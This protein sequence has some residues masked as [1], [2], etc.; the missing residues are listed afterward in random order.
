MKNSHVMNADAGND[1]LIDAAVPSGTCTSSLFD[2]A[3]GPFGRRYRHVDGKSSS[4]YT[5]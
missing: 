2:A 3:D 5:I 4:K 1:I